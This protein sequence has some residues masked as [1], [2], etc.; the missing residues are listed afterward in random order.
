MVQIKSS[1]SQAY[2]PALLAENAP[3]DQGSPSNALNLP[4]K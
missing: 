4:L 1:A 2:D 3:S